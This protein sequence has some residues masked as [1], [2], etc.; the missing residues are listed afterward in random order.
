MTMVLDASASP[1]GIEIRRFYLPTQR[2]DTIQLLARL[3]LIT[4]PTSMDLR[5]MNYT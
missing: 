4:F 3:L 5:K 2:V 1:P